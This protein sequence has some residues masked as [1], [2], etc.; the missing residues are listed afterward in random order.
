M[1]SLTRL[2]PSDTVTLPSSRCLALTH[3]IIR[4]LSCRTSPHAPCATPGHTHVTCSDAISR[5]IA[6]NPIASTPGKD[7][8]GLTALHITLIAVFV[9]RIGRSDGLRGGWTPKV[10]D[11]VLGNYKN[12]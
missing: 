5:E 1:C 9:P 6:S 7:D 4:S 10:G 12:S 3:W 8:D 2:Y 11:K